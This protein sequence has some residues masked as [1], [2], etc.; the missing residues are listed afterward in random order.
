MD[1]STKDLR[2]KIVLG[3]NLAVSRLIES[4]IESDGELV[5]SIDGKI[6]RI[7]AREL[8]NNSHRD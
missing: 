8:K 3:V 6:V 5:Y 2:D 1:K 7:K 4:K